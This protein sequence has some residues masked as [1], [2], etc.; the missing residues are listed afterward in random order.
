MWKGSHNEMNDKGID[1]FRLYV[2]NGVNNESLRHGYRDHH[3]LLK[4]VRDLIGGTDEFAAPLLIEVFLGLNRGRANV[5]EIYKALVGLVDEQS[6]YAGL[7]SLKRANRV[8]T[9]GSD[10][11]YND[12]RSIQLMEYVE[13][14]QEMYELAKRVKN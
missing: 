2:N 12:L 9:E 1:E 6:V 13:T 5:E 3:E 4:Y 8:T 10:V 14:F 7:E 11:V